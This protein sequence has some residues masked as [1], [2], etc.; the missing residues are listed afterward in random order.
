LWEQGENDHAQDDFPSSPNSSA[1]AG[2]S[3][4]VEGR[5]VSPGYFQAMGIPLESGRDFTD[6]DNQKG[7]AAFAS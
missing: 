4:Y 1:G 5:S 2:G 3:V 6:A 7:P